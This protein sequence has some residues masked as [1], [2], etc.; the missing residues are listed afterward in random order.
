MAVVNLMAKPN[1]LLCILFDYDTKNAL[2]YESNQ[3]ADTNMIHFD[4]SSPLFNEE[5][6]LCV[7]FLVSYLLFVCVGIFS[8]F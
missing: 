3:T 2:H 5:R 7:S 6:R 4:W 8:D 1:S